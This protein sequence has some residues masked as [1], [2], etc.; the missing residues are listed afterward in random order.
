M[1][2]ETQS[3][4]TP[5]PWPLTSDPSSEAQPTDSAGMTEGQLAEAKRYGRLD[6]IC[7]LADKSLDVAYLAV[8]GLL[9]ARPIDGWLSGRPLLDTRCLRYFM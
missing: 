7:A 8:T 6:L 2:D 3:P 4:L 9:L 1:S 5:D